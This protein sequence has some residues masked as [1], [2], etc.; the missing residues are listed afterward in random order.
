MGSV[1]RHRK[2]WPC[3]D[4]RERAVGKRGREQAV[5]GAVHEEHGVSW[6]LLVDSVPPP[7]VRHR[8]FVKL[9]LSTTEEL[10]DWQSRSSVGRRLGRRATGPRVQLAGAAQI[11]AEEFSA[12]SGDAG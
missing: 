9:L 7:G 12:R 5:S 10:I 3:R 1:V 8:V 4:F 2:C 11:L 6:R